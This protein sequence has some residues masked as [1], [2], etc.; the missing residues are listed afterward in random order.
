MDY[1]ML[2][3]SAPYFDLMEKRFSL[4][5]PVIS[6]RSG[7]PDIEK[8]IGE[9]FTDSSVS[10]PVGDLYIGT[11]AGSDGHIQLRLFRGQVDAVGNPSEDTDMEVLDQASGPSGPVRIIDSMVGYVRATPPAPDPAP[12]H[13]VHIKGCNI[14]QKRFLPA[15]GKPDVPFLVRLKKV[16]G[17]NVNVTAP[18]HFHGLRSEYKGYFEYM[19][20]EFVVA[21]KPEK[22]GNRIVMKFTNR[23]QLLAAYR[24][25]GAK[26][27]NGAD[28]L[29]DDWKTIVPPVMRD[30]RN[31]KKSYP[32]GRTIEGETTV[33]IG[34]Q[35]RIEPETVNWSFDYHA[36][37]PTNPATRLADIKA[38]MLAD[39]RF[40]S[41]HAWPVFERWRF[42]TAASYVDGYHWTFTPRGTVLHATGKRFIYTIVDPIVDRS[43]TPV[44][45]RPLIYNFYPG[46]GSSQAA[47]LT[48]IVESDNNFFGRA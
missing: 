16:F 2:A 28:V 30:Q 20:H 13:S 8:F 23:D 35:L 44:Q 47:I 25:I 14:G 24:G 33:T 45:D 4:D 21:K 17:D 10:K 40:A 7:N 6:V 18:K 27:H 9:L 3:Q 36:T 29:P 1:G 15:A 43:V 5:Q 32:L 41:T 12:T 38:D 11:H 34:R 46:P 42:S 22:V 48:G 26:Y 19:A 31:L 37:P 39:P